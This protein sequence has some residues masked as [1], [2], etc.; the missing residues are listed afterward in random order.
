MLQLQMPA[1]S[2]HDSDNIRA[3]LRDRSIFSHVV[4]EDGRKNIETR[5]L[6]C[7]M[8][9]TLHSFSENTVL[10][11]ICYKV[12]GDLLPPRWARQHTLRE[13]YGHAFALGA[14][15]FPA[16]YLHLWLH[17]IRNFPEL[18]DL[19]S[20]NV[21]KDK[22]RPKPATRAVDVLADRAFYSGFRT[23]V[24]ARLRKQCRDSPTLELAAHEPPSLGSDEVDILPRHRCGRPL[25]SD[26]RRGRK[27][28]FLTHL[29][30]LPRSSPGTYAT[31]F[32]VAREMIFS[33]WADDVVA[34]VVEDER[35]GGHQYT[36][37]FEADTEDPIPQTEQMSIGSSL[38]ERS[39][40]DRS[41]EDQPRSMSC[42]ARLDLRHE[43]VDD[44]NQSDRAVAVDNAGTFANPDQAASSRQPHSPDIAQHAHIALPGDETR[45]RAGHM[46]SASSIY[47]S[48][49]HGP[50]ASDDGEFTYNGR[51]CADERVL[52]EDDSSTI[53]PNTWRDTWLTEF[54]GNPFTTSV[55]AVDGMSHRSDDGELRTGRR[56]YNLEDRK[57]AW[58]AGERVRQQRSLQH[59]F[60]LYS[61][62]PVE[63][64][65][66]RFKGEVSGNVLVYAVD[67]ESDFVS[68][69]RAI[70][71]VLRGKGA[72]GPSPLPLYYI[73]RDSNAS[74]VIIQSRAIPLKDA[75]RS[76]VSS[77]SSHGGIVAFNLKYS[78]LLSERPWASPNAPRRSEKV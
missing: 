4:G 12:L 74:D 20:G 21:R 24:I 31:W 10:L 64:L 49:R 60:C 56:K 66:T 40:T 72:P 18:S 19:R 65:D 17:V 11:E 39:P 22:G 14:E 23:E 38:P 50:R 47:S 25:E 2:T 57:Q 59:C 67:A 34:C 1:Y 26:F 27:N 36:Y 13:A 15:Q 48:P 69:L 44:R 70:G 45:A 62:T 63:R 77:P 78:G 32:A 68:D 61:V 37:E 53:G 46:L 54:N 33:F 28:L 6:T 41:A 29:L 73:Y 42:G 52:F 71:N 5:I 3:W 7:R 30:H 43:S 35:R 55:S 9:G 51:Q 16:N 76:L 75:W 58:Q 8:I